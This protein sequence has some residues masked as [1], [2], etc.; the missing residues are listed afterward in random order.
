M[1]A[2]AQPKKIKGANGGGKMRN[3][4]KSEWGPQVGAGANEGQYVNLA[5]MYCTFYTTRGSAFVT[6]MATG[7]SVC[8]IDSGSKT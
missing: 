4:R 7:T 2:N 3:T 5:R 8:I 1:S 6:Q